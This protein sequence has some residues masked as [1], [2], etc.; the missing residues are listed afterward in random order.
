MSESA[1]GTREGRVGRRLGP[2]LV[3]GL[4]LSLLALFAGASDYWTYYVLSSH[5]IVVG[6]S[7]LIASFVACSCLLWLLCVLADA[8]GSSH[9]W[10]RTYP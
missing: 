1:S 4:G 5:D 6:V 10:S 2:R 7:I 3:R 9:G 8:V